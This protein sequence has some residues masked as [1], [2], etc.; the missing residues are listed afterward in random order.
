MGITFEG[1][2]K[3]RI[4]EGHSETIQLNWLG[5]RNLGKTLEGMNDSMVLW[6]PIMENIRE[7]L[8]KME[9]CM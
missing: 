9:N 2:A 4:Y 7:G 6:I 8:E 5:N 1:Y 3:V